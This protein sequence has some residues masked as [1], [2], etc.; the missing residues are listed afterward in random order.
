MRVL[1]F[2][3]IFIPTDKTRNKRCFFNKKRNGVVR[4]SI[5]ALFNLRYPISFLVFSKLTIV[6]YNTG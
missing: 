5:L 1:H 3:V 6:S 4:K 2:F